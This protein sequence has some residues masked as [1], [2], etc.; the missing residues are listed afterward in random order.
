M[1]SLVRYVQHQTAL[2]NS[3]PIGDNVVDNGCCSFRK[4]NIVYIF[5]LRSNH[6]VGGSATYIIDLCLKYAFTMQLLEC[7]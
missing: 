4:W 7:D 3:S 6:L 1:Y 2:Q 5:P